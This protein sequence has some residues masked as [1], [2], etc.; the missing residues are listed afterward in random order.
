MKLSRMVSLKIILTNLVQLRKFPRGTVVIG[1]RFW[2]ALPY[3]TNSSRE[4]TVVIGNYCS[5]ARNCMI[6]P[7]NGHIPESREDERFR[8]STY[9][10]AVFGGWK[11]EYSLPLKHNYVIVGNDVWVGANTVILP[12]VKIG[13]GA[14]VGAGS[15]VTHDIPPYA[16]AAGAP[17]KVIRY[18]YSKDQRAKLLEIAWWNWPDKVVAANQDYFYKDIDIFIDKF[19]PKQSID[20]AEQTTEFTEISKVKAEEKLE[21]KVQNLN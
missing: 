12:G 16:V 13:D 8:V 9:P 20:K 15:I 10:I 11:K 2:G 19:M 5:F 7:N 1:K 17:A 6:V 3:I 4:D 18:R 21:A 14:I